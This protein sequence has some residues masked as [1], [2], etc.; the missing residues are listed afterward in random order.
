LIATATASWK[1]YTNAK[2]AYSI[3]YPS[4][5]FN[6]EFPEKTGSAFVLSSTPN[7]SGSQEININAIA[8]ISDS[9]SL[10][11]ADYVQ[12]AGIKEFGY[13]K[14]ASIKPITTTSGISGYETTWTVQSS[15][16]QL[17]E[18]LPITYF[19]ISSDK[20]ATI[21]VFLNKEDD[22]DIYNQMLSTFEFTQ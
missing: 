10:S 11:F 14:L 8:K 13:T 9:L 16:G 17:S 19:E 22:L 7:S 2:Y 21:E 6:S 4:N 18:S 12:I 3:E 5:W 20:T 15:D 1:T